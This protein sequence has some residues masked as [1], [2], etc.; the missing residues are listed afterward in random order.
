[1]VIRVLVEAF[2]H[3][4]RCKL[5]PALT[6]S[7]S[8]LETDLQRRPPQRPN[9]KM[10]HASPTCGSMWLTA[11]NAFQVC[12]S[13]R[14]RLRAHLKWSASIVLLG[15]LKKDHQPVYFFDASLRVPRCTI[16]WQHRNNTCCEDRDRVRMGYKWI[17]R[18]IRSWKWNFQK[19]EWVNS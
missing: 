3:K 10:T 6:Q 8:I 13:R 15:W 16:F 12:S 19:C 1:M 11:D 4:T 18:P 14:I 5:V 9:A 17:C 7:L 2:S